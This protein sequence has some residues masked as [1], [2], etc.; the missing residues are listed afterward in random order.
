MSFMPQLNYYGDQGFY[1][2]KE[3]KTGVEDTAHPEERKDPWKE[4][5]EQ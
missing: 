4:E 5:E 2:T 1:C 3:S